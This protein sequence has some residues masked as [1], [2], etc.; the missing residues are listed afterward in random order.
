MNPLLSLT[1]D[2]MP[3]DLKRFAV[4]NMSL[5]SARATMI[6]HSFV[7]ESTAHAIVEYLN[8]LYLS[9]VAESKVDD[10]RFGGP[11]DELGK[12]GYP[13]LSRLIEVP[14]LLTLVVGDYL[15]RDLIDKFSWDRH[16]PIEY[17]LD[18]VSECRAVEHL[19]HIHGICYSKKPT[20][21]GYHD[22]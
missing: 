10:E 16:S 9:W 6:A 12:A 22:A 7:I 3:R 5:S 2:G 17:W 19:I 21:C 4:P 13:D 8:T 14:E 15:G 20:P 11:D 18:D 1:V